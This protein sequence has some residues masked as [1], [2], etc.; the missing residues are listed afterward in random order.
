MLFTFLI[1]IVISTITYRSYTNHHDKSVTIGVDEVIPTSLSRGTIFISLDGEGKKCSH[2]MPCGLIQGL[3]KVHAGDVVFFRG[4][5]YDLTNIPNNQIKLE[6]GSE[7]NQTVYES[8][9]TELA[10]FDGSNL[11]NHHQ[12]SIFIR[13]YTTLRR[14]EVRNMSGAGVK[15]RGNHN[16]IEGVKTHHNLSSGIH[17]FSRHGYQV[18]DDG[19]SYNI[20]KNCVSHHNSDAHL[21][22]EGN[23]ADGISISSGMNNHIINTTVYSNSD[24][25]IDTWKSINSLVEYCMSYDNGKGKQ[26][27]GIGFKLGGDMNLSSELGKGNV[28]QFNIA[29]NNRNSGFSANSGKEIIQKNNTSYNNG[30]Y[31]I[32]CIRDKNALISHNITY[33]NKKGDFYQSKTLKEKNSWQIK[34]VTDD[35]FISLDSNSKDFLK[36]TAT[37]ELLKIGAYATEP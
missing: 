32:V 9:P 5:V 25:G 31:G 3:K 22:S 14:V 12:S 7:G 4:G 26:G 19:G 33:K 35:D 27:N 6:G 20:I 34:Q 36:P 16:S 28:A 15:I 17:I 10:I 8:Y 23:G 11:N 18:R 21:S 1:L 30:Q 13:D 37:S 29:Y 2:E 24:D